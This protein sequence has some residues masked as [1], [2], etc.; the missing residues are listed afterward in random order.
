MQLV[1]QTSERNTSHHHILLTVTSK[2][3]MG[4][5][6]NS[7]VRFSNW[8][9]TMQRTPVQS[10]ETDGWHT[11]LDHSQIIFLASLSAAERDMIKALLVRHCN[12]CNDEHDMQSRKHFTDALITRP[13]TPSPIFLKIFGDV[14]SNILKPPVIMHTVNLQTAQFCNSSPCRQ[15]VPQLSTQQPR[16][17]PQTNHVTRGSKH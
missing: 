4:L 8:N 11:A 10:I 7:T 13:L 14:V 1:K 15:Y 12:K 5:D 3:T 9:Y 17:V 6:G 16:R 2:K